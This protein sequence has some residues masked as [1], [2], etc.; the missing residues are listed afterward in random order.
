MELKV[1][2]ALYTLSVIVKG[3]WW[4]AAVRPII[5]SLGAIFTAID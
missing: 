3:A 4:A 1:I 2:F 5:L